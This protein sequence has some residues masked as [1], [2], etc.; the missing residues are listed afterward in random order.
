MRGAAAGAQ[1]AALGCPS[2]P[3]GSS[4]AGGGAAGWVR[5][6]SW[7]VRAG[8]GGRNLAEVL[9]DASPALRPER[10]PDAKGSGLGISVG[11][12]LNLSVGGALNVSPRLEG[13]GVIRFSLMWRGKIFQLASGGSF[14]SEFL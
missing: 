14:L 5:D 3:R 12:P 9:P 6:S 4:G 11:K 13:N 8:E 10:R 7:G 2:C 1:G